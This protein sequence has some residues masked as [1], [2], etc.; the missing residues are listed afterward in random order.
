[1]SIELTKKNICSESVVYDGFCEQSIDSDINLPD[2]CPDIMRILKCTIQPS[3]TNSKIVGDRATAD[4]NAKIR[5]IYSDEKNNIYCYDADYPFSKYTELSAFTDSAVLFC[6]AKTDYANCRAV[7]KRRLDIHGAVSLHF[8]ITSCTQEPVITSACGGGVQLKRKGTDISTAVASAVKTFQISEVKNVGDSNPGIGKVIFSAASP[9]INETKIIKGKM[10]IK[11]ELTVKA[12]YCSDSAQNESA[13]LCC[14]IP[15]NEILESA[16]FSDSCSANTELCVTYLLAEPKVDNDGEYRFMNISADICAKSTAYETE[17]LTVIT[18]AY[19]TE[20]QLEIRHNALKLPKI[21][22]K[23]SETVIC[24]Q[25]LDISSVNP[26]KLFTC[27]TSEARIRC[28]FSDSKII[29]NGKIPLC[30]ILISSDGSP[31]SCE[32]EAE[33]EYSGTLDPA[34]KNPYCNPNVQITGFSCLLTPDGA[35]DFKAEICVSGTVFNICEEKIITALSP[36]ESTNP[37]QKRSSL[38]VYF[39]SGNESLWEIARR[40]NTTVEEI[41]EENELS[42]DYLENKTMLMIPIK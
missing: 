3:V 10:L 31:V 21:Q 30:L 17:S 28:S 14:S 16:G 34:C 2:Y 32:R 15:F 35:V 33:F 22:Q 37:K 39:C 4:G 12:V 26:E 18:D 19:S 29:I 13:E 40:Y 24:R 7:S 36:S 25:K 23:I 8:R 42:A 41:M 5:V 11:G 27:L 9:V 38:T 1:M 20:A 6:T